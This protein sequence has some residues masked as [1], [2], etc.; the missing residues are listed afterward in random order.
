MVAGHITPVLL[1]AVAPLDFSRQAAVVVAVLTIT[2]LSRVCR[3]LAVTAETVEL[4]LPP[5]SDDPAHPH[6]GHALRAGRLIRFR[7]GRA[8]S[9]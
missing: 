5:I 9:L 6:P 4:S 3:A 8:G 2:G 7:L 1:L